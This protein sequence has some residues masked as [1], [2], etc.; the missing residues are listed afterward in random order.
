MRSEPAMPHEMR[1]G[2]RRKPLGQADT[3]A[4]AWRAHALLA[5]KGVQI[6]SNR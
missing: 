5:G 6:P 2:A 3:R 4:C 1:T